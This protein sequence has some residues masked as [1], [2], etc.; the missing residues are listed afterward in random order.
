MYLSYRCE[1]KNKQLFGLSH[2]GRLDYDDIIS[3]T[4]NPIVLSTFLQ[5]ILINYNDYRIFIPNINENSLLY[6]IFSRQLKFSEN[7]V[8]IFLPSNYD[9]YIHS[10]S[11]HQQQNVRT[12]YNRM[13]RAYVIYHLVQYNSSNRMS[14][15][16]WR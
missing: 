15:K 8:K 1:Q 14:Q 12:A 9:F 13:S 4:G 6:T 10:L 16:M 3:S 2:F 7:C 11:K 5:E